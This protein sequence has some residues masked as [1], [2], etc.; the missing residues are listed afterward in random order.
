DGRRI[1]LATWIL[2]MIGTLLWFCWRTAQRV[3]EGDS[4]RC[5]SGSLWAVATAG[6]TASTYVLIAPHSS[7]YHFAPIA[8]AAAAMI[9]WM[10]TRSRD[11]LMMVCLGTM[12]LIEVIPGRDVIGGRLADIKLAYGSVGICAFMAMIGALRV[13]VRASRPTR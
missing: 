6:A 5:E 4:G 11:T 7:N 8:I 10:L 1:V 2:A 9:G 3:G 13:M 12:I